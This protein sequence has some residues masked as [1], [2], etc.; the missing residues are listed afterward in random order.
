MFI[1]KLKDLS[2][3]ELNIVKLMNED[4]LSLKDCEDLIKCLEK[5][6]KIIVNQGYVSEEMS[7]VE[8]KFTYLRCIL[9][10]RSSTLTEE[11]YWNS[12]G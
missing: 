10:I 5:I 9:S 6:D 3:L 1:V 8:T 4:K 7:K 2:N 12:V 11:D